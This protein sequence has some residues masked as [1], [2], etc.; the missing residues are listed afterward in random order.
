MIRR[1][2]LNAVYLGVGH[3]KVIKKTL[4]GQSL[5]F[6][7]VLGIVPFGGPF[8]TV[9]ELLFERKG[10]IPAIQRLLISIS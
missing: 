8:G 7:V 3:G 4:P 10:L 2:A 1:L 9:P 5:E 6:R